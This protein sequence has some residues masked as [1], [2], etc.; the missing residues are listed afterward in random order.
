MDAK[1]FLKRWRFTLI[2]LSAVAIG[3]LLGYFLKEKAV[4]LK[5]L[6]DIFLNLLFTAVVPLVFFS[7]SSAIAAASNPKRLGKIAASMLLVFVIT[8]IISS[9]LMLFAVKTFNPA[10]GITLQSSPH[11]SQTANLSEKIVNTVSVND[12]S[13]LLNRKNILALIVFS[14]LTGLASQAAGD[15]GEKFR[16]FLISGAEVMAHLIKIIMLYAPIGLSAYFAYIV[17]TFGSQILGSYARVAGLYF[18]V[19]LLYF[20]IGFSIYAFLGAG[21]KGMKDFWANIWPPALTAFGTGSSLAALPANL[22]AAEKIGIPQDVREIVLPLGASIHM[23]GTCL[24]AIMKIAVLFTLY[25]REFS[26]FETLAG[27]V[28]VAILCGVVMSGIPGGGFLGEALIVS[29]YGFGP[30]ALPIIS[31]IGTVVDAPA[32]MINSAGDTAA[33]MIVSRFTAK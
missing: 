19:A 17:G 32:T 21:R 18:P 6:G 10:K 22:V 14:V 3:A 12:F 13:G 15:K 23:D 16:Q 29:L 24:A 9:C 26:G 4:K 8:G 1:V 33:A 2:L 5:P 27:A 7:L 20:V 11:S 30:E 31:M 28:G 25:G